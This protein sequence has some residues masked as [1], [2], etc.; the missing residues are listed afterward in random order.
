MCKAVA[1]DLVDLSEEDGHATPRGRSITPE[2][3]AQARKA[4]LACP[5][6]AV[7]LVDVE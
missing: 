2:L 6:G 3:D 1:P 7:H 5:E 4:V